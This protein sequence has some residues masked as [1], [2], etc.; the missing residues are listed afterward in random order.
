MPLDV[1]GDRSRS[2][3]PLPDLTAVVLGEELDDGGLAGLDRFYGRGIAGEDRFDN[4]AR[5]VN[6]GDSARDR[7][8][9]HARHEVILVHQHRSA[10]DNRLDG[11]VVNMPRFV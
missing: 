10:N 7:T 8:T 9:G 5:L 4:A 2:E 11:V 1:G 3:I 6:R